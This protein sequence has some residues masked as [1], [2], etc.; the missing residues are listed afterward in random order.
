MPLK[1]ATW[2]SRFRS[3]AAG[4]PIW[5]PIIFALAVLT[6]SVYSSSHPPTTDLHRQEAMALFVGLDG[7]TAVYSSLIV[8]GA[9][10]KSC[11]IIAY[12]AVVIALELF[13]TW[14]TFLGS[15]IL[16]PL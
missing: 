7:L 10:T 4:L 9:R 5:P 6:A 2:V 15:G 14:A 12:L 11:G 3:F 1:G 16:E 13:L 8:Y